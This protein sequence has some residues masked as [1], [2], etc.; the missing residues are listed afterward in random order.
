[1]KVLEGKVW[2]TGQG[3]TN[4]CVGI[5]DDGYIGAVKKI[6]KGDEHTTTSDVILPAA[7]DMHVHFRDPGNPEKEVWATGSAA[8]ACGASPGTKESATVCPN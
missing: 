5:N 8:A 1:M 3:L 6:L 4:A 2:I 7:T